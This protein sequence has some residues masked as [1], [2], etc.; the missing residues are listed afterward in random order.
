MAASPSS[1]LTQGLGAWGT[2]SLLV[3]LGY[4]SG[5]APT[6]A[7]ITGTITASITEADIRT[8]GK[9]L[10]ITLTN[11]TWA[12]AGA[13]FDAQRQNIINGIDSAQAEATGWDAVVKAGLAVGTVVRTSATVVTVT[14]PAF[15][16]Y[17]ITAT[18]TI[19]VTIPASALVTSLVAVVGVPTFTVSALADTGTKTGTGGIDAPRNGR[20]GIPRVPFKPTG[21]VSPKPK[22]SKNANIESRLRETAQQHAEVTA[23]LAREFTEDNEARAAAIDAE[24]V[25]LATQ[26]EIEDGISALL[27]K[28]QRTDDEELLLLI[29]MAA[30]T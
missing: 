9:T 24:R 17:D 7:A 20:E 1:V 5:V 13:A 25:A 12:A 23:K 3:T 16:T 4:G 15:A 27:R 22:A 30:S 11:D 21:L 2:P 18:E 19:T 26:A 8:G 10:I 6:T 29:L 28:R 14:L